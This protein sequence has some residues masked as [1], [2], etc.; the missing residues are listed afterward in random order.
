MRTGAERSQAANEYT[1][2]LEGVIDLASSL[3]CDQFYRPDGLHEDLIDDLAEGWKDRFDPSMKQVFNAF[4]GVDLEDCVDDEISHYFYKAGLLGY[5]AK[6]A[7]PVYSHVD[8]TSR[9]Y[10]WGYYT[11]NLFYGD[12]IEE[13]WN[14]AIEWSKKHLAKAIAEFAK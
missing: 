8:D 4:D 6:F 2:R 5:I 9:S 7:T 11:T 12:T 3:E 1:L 14:H 13:C 10:S